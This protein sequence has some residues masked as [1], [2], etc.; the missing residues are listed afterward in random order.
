MQVLLEKCVGITCPCRS[1]KRKQ[2]DNF[3]NHVHL[4]IFRNILCMLHSKES[5]LCGV[6]GVANGPPEIYCISERVR[7]VILTASVLLFSWFFIQIDVMLLLSDDTVV[8]CFEDEGGRMRLFPSPP[9]ETSFP[10]SL[11]A[12]A[13]TSFLAAGKTRENGIIFLE[14][15]RASLSF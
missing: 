13:G 2:E 3:R 11:L 8:D 4:S 9:W 15:W 12:G 7:H 5:F 14:W 1:R 6:T 10:T